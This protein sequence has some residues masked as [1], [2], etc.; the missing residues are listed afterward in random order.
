MGM[1]VL[2]C[3]NNPVYN[4]DTEE[5]YNKQLLPGYMRK[6]PNKIT[7]KT[8]LKMRYSSNTNSIARALK[9]ISFGQGNRVSI[10]RQ[11]FALSLSDCYWIKD[12][13]MLLRFEQVSPYYVDFWRGGCDYFGGSIPTLYVDGYMDKEWVNR[14]TLVKYGDGIFNEIKA[15]DACEL[16]GINVVEAGVLKNS[17]GIDCLAVNNMTSPRVMLETAEMSGMLD[18]DDFD[19]NTILQLFK[20]TGVQML[21]IDAI[22]GN[23][24]RHA[25]NFG[26]FRDTETGNYLGQATLYDFDHAFDSNRSNDLLIRRLVDSIKN[27]KLFKSE[28]IRICNCIISKSN[29]LVFVKRARTIKLKLGGVLGDEDRR[30]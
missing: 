9:G 3:V 10:N 6:N 19:E 13:G 7:F 23:G 1:S 5:V 14:D 29:E 24:D 20:L 16:C 11:T 4:I 2:Y 28:A 8:W 22:V 26:M 25:G 21:T 12:S 17:A 30:F 27:I 18:P 15:I